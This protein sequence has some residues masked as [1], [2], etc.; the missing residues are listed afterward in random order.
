MHVTGSAT[1]E[2]SV[3]EHRSDTLAAWVSTLRTRFP[4]PPLAICLDLN[5]GPL[6]SALRQDDFLVFFPI[7]PL[8]LARYREAFT[9]SQA[10]DDPTDAARLLALLRKHRDQLTPLQPQ[11]PTMRAL[12]QRVEHRR[13]LVGDHVRLT[14]RLT[15]T[16]KH[17]FPQVLPW[18]HDQDTAIF[19]DV[20]TP[21]PTR[22]AV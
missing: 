16:L 9:P 1:R 2:F 21:W 12:A 20:L 11:S 15:S 14:N 19:C 5:Q 10:K 13:R 8:M 3:L 17:D 7:T 6:V 22:K 4:G 18:F